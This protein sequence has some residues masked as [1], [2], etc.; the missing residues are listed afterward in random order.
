MRY[1]DDLSCQWHQAPAGN[2]SNVKTLMFAA[3]GVLG[4]ALCHWIYWMWIWMNRRE[5]LNND[6]LSA[7]IL[8]ES[9][10]NLES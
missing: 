9:K 5:I 1:F 3:P 4:G 2:P 8:M 6:L 10:P 7:N